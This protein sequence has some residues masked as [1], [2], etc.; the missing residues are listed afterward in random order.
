ML[1]VRVEDAECGECFSEEVYLD[2]KEE[3]S[4]YKIGG[5]ALAVTMTTG[6]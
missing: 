5:S 6:L 2:V 1:G 4:S 3:S